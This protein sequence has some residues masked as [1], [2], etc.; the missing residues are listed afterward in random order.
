MLQRIRY[1]LVLKC[2][3]LLAAVDDQVSNKNHDTSHAFPQNLMSDVD[4]LEIGNS[5]T[6]K[7]PVRCPQSV[8]RLQSF[9]FR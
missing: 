1:E 6:S 5:A 7:S 3:S 8:A 9:H 2:R 4:M